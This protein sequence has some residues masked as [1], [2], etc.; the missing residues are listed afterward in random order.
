[1]ANVKGSALASRVTWVRLN[2]GQDGIERLCEAVSPGLAG[3][4][5]DGVA[6][7]TWY[8]FVEFVELST[9]IDLLF[10]QGDGALIKVLGRVG[11]EANMTTIYRLFYKVGTVKW[12]MARAARLWHL[13]YDAGQLSLRELASGE[14]ELTIEGF[15]TPSCV[16][17]QSVQGWAER[18]CEL[19]G[20]QDVH[21]ETHSC[22]LEGSDA[23]RLRARWR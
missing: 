19:S 2:H 22:R 13:H 15:P 12:V 20:G 7:A 14:I 5:R 10:G 18:S 6:V 9:A 11:A 23:C 17:C 4:I 21:T 16:H 8:P 1:M 3:A